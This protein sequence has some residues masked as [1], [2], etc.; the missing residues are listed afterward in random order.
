MSQFKLRDAGQHRTSSSHPGEASDSISDVRPISAP[1][2]EL[3]SR[4]ASSEGVMYRSSG[5]NTGSNPRGGRIQ[6][7]RK[8]GS[9]GN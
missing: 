8:G 7:K 2:L 4:A 5:P 3:L 6:K 9:I 1:A